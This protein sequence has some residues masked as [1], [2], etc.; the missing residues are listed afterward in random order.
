[1]NT[2]WFPVVIFEWVSLAMQ[3]WGF[4]LDESNDQP[5]TRVGS[6]FLTR[7]VSS[8][9]VPWSRISSDML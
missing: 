8:M 6:Q 2:S 1:M 5:V 3:T 4:P 7:E 9:M